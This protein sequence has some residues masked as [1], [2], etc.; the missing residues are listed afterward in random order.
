MANETPQHD[1]DTDADRPLPTGNELIEAEI[2][3]IVA[4]GECFARVDALPKPTMLYINKEVRTALGVSEEDALEIDG[5]TYTV[6]SARPILNAKGVAVFAPTI[7]HPKHLAS[8]AAYFE[9]RGIASP[10]HTGSFQVAAKVATLPMP[11]DLHLSHSMRARFGLALGEQVTL[12]DGTNMTVCEGR[13][14]GQG[15]KKV[16]D[17]LCHPD[18]EEAVRASLRTKLAEE[19]A[20]VVART[21]G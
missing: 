12:D 14:M 13:T 11:G 10:I 9:S 3:R 20:R 6:K 19:A 4:A 2:D 16:V 8:V 21:M 18:M 1:R 15:A 7:V 5:L 17:V